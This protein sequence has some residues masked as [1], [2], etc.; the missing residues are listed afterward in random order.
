[1]SVLEGETIRRTTDAAIGLPENVVQSALESALRPLAMRVRK[2]LILP[3]DATRAFSGVGDITARCVRILREFCSV[4]VMPALG[5]HMPMTADESL[6][7]FGD[8]IDPAR[9]ISHDWRGDTIPIGEIPGSYVSAVTDGMFDRP[10][11]AEVN[12]RLFDPSYDLVLSLGQVVPHE[13]AGMA[14]YSKNIFVG[15]GG[16]QMIHQTHLISA[17]WGIERVLGEANTPTRALYHYAQENL[18]TGMP[19]V[20]IMTVS[21]PHD[22][23]NRTRGLFIGQGRSLFEEASRLSARINIHWIDHPLKRVV[24]FSDPE[25]Y[26][27]TWVANKAVYR[28]RMAIAEG[29]ELIILA[30]GVSRFGEDAANDSLIRKY[31]Y[32]GTRKTYELMRAESDLAA[33]PSAAAHMM[34]GS[35][36]G[37]FRVT[38]AVSAISRAE[39]DSVGY[40]SAAYADMLS[41]LFTHKFNPS[42]LPEEGLYTDAIGEEFYFLPHPGAGLWKA[43]R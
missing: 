37:R 7:M 38:Y 10:I 16:A 17:A 40:A 19:L 42:A 9:L 30:P 18:L 31:G 2:A 1:M 35:T 14:N 25:E 13:V 34:H 23:I 28:S 5:T 3:P 36:D 24:A 41:L 6:R 12:R 39:I 11:P 27:T 29:G 4:D 15:C 21:A 32:G 8:A 22:G 43:R 33:N 26:K 20:Y